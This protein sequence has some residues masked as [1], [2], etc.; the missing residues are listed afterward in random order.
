MKDNVVI[1][2]VQDMSGIQRCDIKPTITK[3]GK[4]LQLEARKAILLDEP[5]DNK[6]DVGNM[7]RYAALHEDR[8]AHHRVLIA[9]DRLI[10]L[11]DG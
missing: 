3:S 10:G 7:W 6:D 4:T 9:G 11:N 8:I 1:W 5:G 2:L